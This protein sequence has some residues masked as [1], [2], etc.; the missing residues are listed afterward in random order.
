MTNKNRSAVAEYLNVFTTQNQTN[1][2]VVGSDRMHHSMKRA[3]Q[4]CESFFED[5]CLNDQNIFGA[6]EG[7]ARLLTLIA[8]DTIRQDLAGKMEEIPLGESRAVWNL[9]KQYVQ[10]NR[11][12][13]QMQRKLKFLVEELQMA[14]LCPR[15]DISVSKT[16]N[17]LL[18][19]PFC[20][21]PK[22]GKVCVPFNPSAI[23]KFDPTTV[24]TIRQLLSEIDQFDV[25]NDDGA[26]TKRNI[27]VNWRMQ[28]FFV[29][30]LFPWISAQTSKCFCLC[31][32]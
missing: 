14:L 24:P 27:P 17:H 28:F 26:D 9:I 23:S 32:L 16:A 4:V 30:L 2:V 31:I 25:I 12:Q 13:G 19:A 11:G 3:H 15:L 10:S 8:D 21:H 20:V 22:T 7:R 6:A 5:I 18:K 29:F 1:R